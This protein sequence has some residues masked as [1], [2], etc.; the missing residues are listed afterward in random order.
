[1]FIKIQAIDLEVRRPG[2]LKNHHIMYTGKTSQCFINGIRLI[3]RCCPQL[4][5]ET[6]S[7][8]RR[9]HGNGDNQP[10]QQNP[11][12]Q[13]EYTGQPDLLQQQSTKGSAKECT[14]ELGR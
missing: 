11:G 1:P 4:Y 2:I 12:H 13:P 14:E 8:A 3:A 10:K 5:H 7:M 9:W 6:G